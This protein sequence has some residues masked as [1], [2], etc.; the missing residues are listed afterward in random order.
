VSFG[1]L[2]FWQLFSGCYRSQQ[3]PTQGTCRSWG[4]LLGTWAWCTSTQ[5][6]GSLREPLSPSF[7]RPKSCLRY[8]MS[9][10]S[11][12]SSKN[13]Q[14]QLGTWATGWSSNSIRRFKTWKCPRWSTCSHAGSSLATRESDPTQLQTTCRLASEKHSTELESLSSRSPRT[15]RLLRLKT[16][17]TNRS[18]SQSWTK[19]TQLALMVVR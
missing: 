3:Q 9:M 14:H 2:H 17:A 15:T 5:W 1:R 7:R 10:D 16:K 11:S 18:H 13:W 4:T 8:P 6:L 12:S 19:R